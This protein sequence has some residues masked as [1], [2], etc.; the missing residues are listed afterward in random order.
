MIIKDINEVENKKSV[1]KNQWKTVIN[2]LLIYS[3]KYSAKC[4]SGRSS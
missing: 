3:A 4:K 1:E 2:L